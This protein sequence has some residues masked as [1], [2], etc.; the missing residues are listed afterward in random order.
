M[1]L[2][3]AAPLAVVGG[4]VPVGAMLGNGPGMPSM[5]L[6]SGALLIFFAVGLSAMSRHVPRAGAFFTYVGY[7]L[8]RPAGMAAA[9]LAFLTYTAAQIAVIAYLGLIL[10][11]DIADLSGLALPWWV[12]ALGLVMLVGV[13]GYRHVDL[14]SKV[15]GVVMVCEI[16]IVL[17]LAVAIL[18]YGGAHGISTVSF[19]PDVVLSGSPALALMFAMSGFFGFE[20]TAIYRDEARAPE[21]TIPRATYGAIAL[22]TLFYTFAS[23]AL[24]EGWGQD[25]RAAVSEHTSRFL[26]VTAERYLGH[27]GAQVISLML[28]AS[29]FACALSFHNV[30]S[31]Y[32]YSMSNAGLLPMAIGKIHSRHNSP[33]LCSLVQTATVVA[34]LGA[35]AA[36][37]MD[38]YSQV[39]TW[40]AGVTSVTVVILMALTC[41][42]VI[43]YLN[44]SGVRVGIWQASIAPGIGLVGLIAV[45]FLLLRNLPLLL[46]DL[47]AAG[48]QKIGWLSLTFYLVMVAFPVFGFAQAAWLRRARPVAYAEIVELISER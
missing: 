15:L 26:I 19:R 24:V 31:R 35:F 6:L 20:S 46:G 45:A 40:L 14:S 33:H 37:R 3:A 17:L 12:W 28:I 2:A 38:P 43:V 18:A 11:N 27:T 21:R 1:V 39:Y 41:L 4:V 42:A 16:A 29:F 34:V 7:G 25:F 9:W 8:G 22:I 30:T 10:G 13:L 44:R 48:A 36:L 23:W 32:Q 5:F 47:D